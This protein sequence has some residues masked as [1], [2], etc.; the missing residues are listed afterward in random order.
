MATL[1]SREYLDLK[2]S[3]QSPFFYLKHGGGE[4]VCGI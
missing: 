2:L 3:I 1:C 4:L